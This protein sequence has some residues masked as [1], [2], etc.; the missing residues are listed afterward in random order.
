MPHAPPGSGSLVAYYSFS[1]G[2]GAAAADSRC[3]TECILVASHS[4]RSG[5]SFTGSI[6]NGIAN[7]WTLGALGDAM[8][9]DPAAS[10]I[11]YVNLPAFSTLKSTFTFSLWVIPL[12]TVTV[13]AEA[14]SG[15]SGTVGQHYVIDAQHGG[16]LYGDASSAGV[17]L[18][19]GTNGVFVVCHS[20]LSSVVH[21]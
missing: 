18:S 7:T 11:V 9:F 1:E 12:Q 8:Y 5:N 4:V 17:G 10:I 19:L 6:S 14:N 21:F 16:A 2:T 20:R 3:E 13:A 15:A